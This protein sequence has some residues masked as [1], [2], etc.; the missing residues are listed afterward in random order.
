M[1]QLAALELAHLGHQEEEKA[2]RHQ[3]LL[4]KENIRQL[5]ISHQGTINRLAMEH[6]KEMSDVRQGLE[7]ENR[8]MEIQFQKRIEVLRSELESR[9]KDDLQ[10]IYMKDEQHVTLLCSNHEES[11]INFK[12]YYNDVILS[13]MTLIN[14]LKVNIFVMKFRFQ[15]FT[16]FDFV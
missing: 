11:I 15:F 12:N 2:L 4:L 10:E 8:Q 6:S 14:S 7:Q 16:M 5:N 13:N 1:E 9:R 3:Q